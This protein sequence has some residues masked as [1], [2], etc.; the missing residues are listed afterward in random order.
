MRSTSGGIL[1]ENRRAYHDF[2]IAETFEA[3]LV[4][5]GA[6]VKSAKLGG[7]SL[8]GGYV[9]FIDG[10]P[11]VV[12]MHIAPYA[13]A[14]KSGLYNPTQTRYLLLNQGEMRKLYGL[15]SQKGVALVPLKVYVHGSRLKLEVGVGQGKK[16]YDKREA[17]K[18]RDLEKEVAQEVKWQTRG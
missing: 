2:D 14:P 9:N 10:R 17:L 6:E 1:S 16:L 18:R 7:I 12:G 4:L 5:S 11:V 8:K 3:G 13:K 15:A